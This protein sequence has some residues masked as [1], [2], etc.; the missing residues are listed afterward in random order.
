MGESDIAEVSPL[1]QGRSWPTATSRSASTSGSTSSTG[2]ATASPA[3]WPGSRGDGPL[4]GYA[5]LSRGHGTWGVEVVVHP[6][7]RKPDGD[8]RHQDL[9]AAALGE[10]GRQ[11]GGHVHLWV[12]KPDDR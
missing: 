6:D 4:V 10:V 5:Q 7:H 3:S 9:L 2:A 12:P 1:L 8:G 11:G